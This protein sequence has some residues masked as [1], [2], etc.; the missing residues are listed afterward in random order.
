MKT[1]YSFDVCS[2]KT[3]LL[4]GQL[5]QNRKRQ[6]PEIQIERGRREAYNDGSRVMVAFALAVSADEDASQNPLP[7]QVERQTATD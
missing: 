4:G 2:S 7:E 5:S 3:R 1:G 6:N